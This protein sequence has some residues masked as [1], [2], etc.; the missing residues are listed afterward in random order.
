MGSSHPVKKMVSEP[1]TWHEEVSEEDREDD[2]IT[3]LLTFYK[4]VLSSL[5]PFDVFVKHIETAV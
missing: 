5:L 4:V 2:K 1:D 3:M